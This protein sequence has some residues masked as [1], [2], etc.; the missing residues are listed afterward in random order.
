VTV[1]VVGGGPAGMT[2]A[3]RAAEEGAR[4]ILLERGEKLGKKLYITGKGRC[5][6]TNTADPSVFQS[7]IRAG[8]AFLRSSL[9]AFD[10]RALREWLRALGV[11]TDEERG[12]RV[13]PSSRKAS[14]VTRALA[15]EME[16]LRVDARLNA[17][18]ESVGYRSGAVASVSLRD[19][20]RLD[21]GAV[22]IATGGMSYPSTGSTGDGYRIAE[23]AG[24]MVD[25]PCPGLVPLVSNEDWV[26]RLQGLSL[27]N[28][29]L[30]ARYHGKRFFDELG[31]LLF[32]HFGVSGPLALSLSSRA[33][34]GASWPDISVSIDLKPGMASEEVDARLVRELGE[35]PRRQL[36]TLLTG[37]VPERL[38]RELPERCGLP[39]DAIA[40]RIRRED[41]RSLA[42]VIKSLPIP[43]A[44]T[45]GFDEAVITRGG[46]NLKEINPRTMESKLVKGLYFAGETLDADALTGGFN[47][48]IA[49]S[50]GRQAGQAAARRILSE[51][52]R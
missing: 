22:I 29:V 17:R 34:D 18:V 39:Q 9:S 42:R 31:E 52:E 19:G 3:I 30:T 2:A 48:Q 14:D 51:Q 12:G 10:S 33:A 8:G 50:T 36:A 35:N 11:P 41:R 32:T 23:E 38:A 28:V 21:C 44:G 13:F 37:W 45:R 49:F 27:R 47:L 26:K 16:R 40:A 20:T 1:V 25:P 7:R 15:A 6:V 4:V 46:V 24:H 43:V 5:N